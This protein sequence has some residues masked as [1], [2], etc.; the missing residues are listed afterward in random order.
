M[1]MWF[2]KKIQLHLYSSTGLGLINA[3]CFST[4]KDKWFE[5]HI[6]WKVFEQLKGA[7]VDF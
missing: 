3:S 7:I 1:E 5:M 6:H 4:Y 2:T